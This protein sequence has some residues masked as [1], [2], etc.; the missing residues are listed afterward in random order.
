MEAR[1]KMSAIEYVTIGAIDGKKIEGRGFVL[2]R[3]RWSKD[4]K[5]L[6]ECNILFI[7]SSEAAHNDELIQIL[8]GTS[9]LSIGDTAGFAKRGGII[10]FVLEDSNVRFEINL[11]SAKQ[12]DLNISS[13]LLSVAKIVKP[14]SHGDK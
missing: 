11:E 1:T 10:N 7:S 5:D 2:K 9:T 4:G 14:E 13:R 12:A 3:L 6:K 8:K